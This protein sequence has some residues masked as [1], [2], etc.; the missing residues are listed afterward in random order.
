VNRDFHTGYET[1]QLSP[2]VLLTRI[3]IPRRAAGFKHYY[4]KV[5]TLKAQAISKVCLAGLKNQREVRVA[6]AA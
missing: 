4:R 1:R 3:R 5:G 6:W 2:D